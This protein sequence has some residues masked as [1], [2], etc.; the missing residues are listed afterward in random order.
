MILQYSLIQVDPLLVRYL[1]EKPEHQYTL[2]VSVMSAIL[3]DQHL[4]TD[5]LNDLAILCCELTAQC[6]SLAPEWLAALYS[7]C[8]ADEA[9]YGCLQPT[10]LGS[11]ADPDPHVFGP[12]GSGSMSQRY[13]SGFG[14]FCR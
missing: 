13:G 5:R 14:S 6:T 8:C 11:V 4:D 2:V 12:P 7:L 1:H 10:L 3:L 9:S